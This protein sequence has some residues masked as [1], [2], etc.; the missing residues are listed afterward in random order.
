MN[1][2][3]SY[4]NKT[5]DVRVDYPIGSEHPKYEFIYP[6]N[7][8][9]LPGTISIDNKE[10]DVYILGVTEPI[11]NPGSKVIPVFTGRAIAVIHRIDDDDDKLIVIPEEMPDLT[12]LQ[13]K[14]AT[15]FQEQHY[16]SAII[17]DPNERIR[18]M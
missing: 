12:D 10:I 15:F 18:G 8:G 14:D 4:I 11:V 16:S 13:I 17:R 7:Y 3:Y 9:H 2:I 5:V 1:N 6:V